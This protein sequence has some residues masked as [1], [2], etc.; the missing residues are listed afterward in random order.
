MLPRDYSGQVCSIARAL[1][2]IGERWSLLIIRDVLRGIH[3][4]DELQSSLGVT[5]SVLSARLAHLVNEGVLERR[6]YQQHPERFEYHLSEKGQALRPVILQLLIWGDRFYPHPDGLPRLLV[7]RGCGGRPD[8]DM[9]CSNCA[10]PLR[11]DMIE[12]TEGPAITARR[13]RAS[14]GAAP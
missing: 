9:C 8:Q 11:T 7:H 10:K 6:R 2:V 13:T 1:E 4:F 5:R 14:A 12:V 3:R